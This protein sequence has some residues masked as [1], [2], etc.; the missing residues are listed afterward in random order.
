M[1]NKSEKITI[2]QLDDLENLIKKID[3]QKKIFSLSNEMIKEKKKLIQGRKGTIS[4]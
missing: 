2:E 1:K 4:K 3:P